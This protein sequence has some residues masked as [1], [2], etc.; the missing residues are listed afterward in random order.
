MMM[1]KEMRSLTSEI[2]LRNDE[3][4]E[5]IEGYALRFD[6][7]SE[8][9]GGRY[10][11]REKISS[12][13]LDSAVM[14]RTVGLINHDEN[15]V[16]GRRNVNMELEV[17]NFGLRFKIK[18][19]DTSYTKDLIE[20]IRSGLINQCSFG[21]TLANEDGAD[22]W[23]EDGDGYLRT[24]NKIGEVFDIS[25]VTTPAYSSTLAIVSNRS[26]SDIDLIEN[27]KVEALERERI[28]AEAQAYL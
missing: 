9:L 19:T 12:H 14:N 20:N 27:E 1:D 7:L 28:L 13:A 6:S 26:M 16:L 4:N 22:T 10:G 11:F 18:P 8:V 5:Y 17:D 3:K 2:E 24:I 25:L 15:M 21:F 23:E